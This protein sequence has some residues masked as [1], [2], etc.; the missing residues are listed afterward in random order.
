MTVTVSGR[1]PEGTA[2]GE[3]TKKYTFRT[4]S[5]GTHTLEFWTFDEMHDGL[6]QDGYTLFYLIRD[7][8]T[9]LP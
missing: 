7:G 4:T 3:T 9:P 6:T 8:M 2:I 1:L 5:G